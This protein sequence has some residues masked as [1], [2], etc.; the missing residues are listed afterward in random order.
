MIAC[1]MDSD[2]YGDLDVYVSKKASRDKHPLSVFNNVFYDTFKPGEYVKTPIAVA[3]DKYK[4]VPQLN[5]LRR[6]D[7]KDT[8]IDL[9]TTP[10]CPKNFII[11]NSNMDFLKCWFDGYKVHFSFD[12]YKWIFK[13][14]GKLLCI[15][16]IEFEH[17]YEPWITDDPESG[18]AIDENIKILHDK[19]GKLTRVMEYSP[20]LP[21]GKSFYEYEENAKNLYLGYENTSNYRLVKTIYRCLK[22]QHRGVKIA[23]IGQFFKNPPQ[24]I[25][26][27]NEVKLRGKKCQFWSLGLPST[28]ARRLL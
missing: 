12:I 17:Y 6:L 19:I 24:T 27:F 5:Y 13:P 22:Y 1:L 10:G 9:V 20:L 8:S 7:L 15:G 3:C 25:S 23:N 21:P 26:H 18:V 14:C 16:S 2:E 4:N 11:S 28:R